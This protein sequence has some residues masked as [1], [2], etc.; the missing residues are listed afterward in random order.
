MSKLW[1]HFSSWT[2]RLCAVLL[3]MGCATPGGVYA[4]NLDVSTTRVVGAGPELLRIWGDATPEEIARDRDRLRAIIQKRTL[5]RPT[6]RRVNYLAISGGGSDGAFGAG[7][8][9][10]WT[11][12]GNR[13]KFDIVSGVSTGALIAPFAFLG[14][15]YDTELRSFY[16]ETSTKD[17]L[18]F[19]FFGNQ[20][21]ATSAPL[22][23]RIESSITMDLMLDVAHEYEQGRYLLVGT[24]NLAAGRPVIWDMGSIA[25]RRDEA[26]LELFRKVI[27]A[28][29]SIPVLFPPV[30]IDVEINGE[31]DKELHVDGGTTDNAIIAPVALNLSELLPRNYRRPSGNLF[32]V[33]NGQTGPFWK[34]VKANALGIAEASLDTVL[35]KQ[36]K[37]DLERLQRFAKS[38]GLK[39]KHTDIPDDFRGEPNELFDPEYM[40]SLF[41]IGY[42]AASKGMKWR[43]TLRSR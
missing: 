6:P 21:L 39:F 10:G 13:P 9:N 17:I 40:S 36:T 4:P 15:K 31:P 38:N 28:S 41:D 27:L 22:Q 5:S 2:T 20:A 43:E 11:K 8:L 12:A 29:A 42:A 35:A 33:V 14:S 16:T 24:T 19:G 7:L 32:V 23:Q 25:T 30:E 26:A 34:P 37:D 1:R 3:V 18:T